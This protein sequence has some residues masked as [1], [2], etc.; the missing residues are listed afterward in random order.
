MVS[1]VKAIGIGIV[2][3]GVVLAGSI[4]LAGTP[5]GA[6]GDGPNETNRSDAVT[7][8]DGGTSNASENRSAAEGAPETDPTNESEAKPPVVDNETTNE[9]EV[10]TP[11]VDNKTTDRDEHPD[12][13][14]PESDDSTSVEDEGHP[15]EYETVTVENVTVEQLHVARVD[16]EEDAEIA[17]ELGVDEDSMSLSDVHI[18]FLELENVSATDLGIT[19]ES[20][21]TVNM[22]D[23]D[24]DELVFRNG[25]VESMNVS[26]VTVETLS[27][28]E[29]AGDGAVPMPVAADGGS[30][31]AHTQANNTDKD[32]KSNSENTTDATDE[33]ATE[34]ETGGTD[35][36]S[37]AS[38]TGTVTADAASTQEITAFTIERIEVDE[39]SVDA[40]AVGVVQD[41]SDV[42]G[43]DPASNGN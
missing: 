19:D 30:S 15:F 23:E 33:R 27:V 7:E 41:P 31:A 37:G 20:G 6:S 2:V 8:H 35:E 1:G 3:L 13:A 43:T 32:C 18:A 12:T 28:A 4:V 29:P 24:A 34:H 26:Q 9:R 22:I 42:P 38:D 16:I 5:G 21:A 40:L 36:T 17:A 11:A 25:T 39:I 10:N 14:A